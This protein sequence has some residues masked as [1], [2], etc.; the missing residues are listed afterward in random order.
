MQTISNTQTCALSQFCDWLTCRNVR[1]IDRWLLL[2]LPAGGGS[3]AWWWPRPVLRGL[4]VTGMPVTGY[5]LLP[6]PS[7]PTL[8]RI[9]DH[10]TARTRRARRACDGSLER[11]LIIVCNAI[12]QQLMNLHWCTYIGRYNSSRYDSIPYTQ[13]R[14]RYDTHPIIVRS[15]RTISQ[16]TSSPD[17]SAYCY[18]QLTISSSVMMDK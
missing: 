12:R 10:K 1:V 4:C 2:S 17:N 8:S 11:P 3:A 16:Y 7:P 6:P 14:F 13:Y 18:T 15:L 5:S 9:M